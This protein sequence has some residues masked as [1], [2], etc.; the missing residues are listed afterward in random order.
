VEDT[1]LELGVSFPLVQ[2][3]PEGELL[4]VGARCWHRPDT[5]PDKNALRFSPEGQQIA[6]ATF[7]DGIEHMLNEHRKCMGRLL[8]RGHLR[9][10]RLGP[11]RWT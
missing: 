4:I 5:G 6:S 8:R 7:G 11:S 2:P 3:L 10:L 1:S 9:Q